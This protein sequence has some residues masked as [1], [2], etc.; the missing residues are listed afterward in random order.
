MWNA[1]VEREIWRSEAELSAA[2]HKL[3]A[4]MADDAI[5]SPR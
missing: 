4:L 2:L 1:I 3:N 5:C